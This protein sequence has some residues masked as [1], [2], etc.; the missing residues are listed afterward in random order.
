MAD[1]T[2]V[3]DELAGKVAGL[4]PNALRACLASDKMMPLIQADRE[5]GVTGGVRATPSFFI[6]EVLLEGV[7][8]AAELRRVLDVAIANAR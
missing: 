2:A 4:D 6:G 1:A 8:P 7:Q 5:K 3:F